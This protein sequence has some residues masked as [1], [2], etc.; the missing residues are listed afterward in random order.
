MIDVV[1]EKPKVSLCSKPYKCYSRNVFKGKCDF[2]HW[3]AEPAVLARVLQACMYNSLPMDMI[4]GPMAKVEKIEDKLELFI[5]YA[6][7]FGVPEVRLTEKE[8]LIS[9]F[10]QEFLF[11]PV[12]DLLQLRDIPKVTRCLAIMAKMVSMEMFNMLLT[13]SIFFLGKC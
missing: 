4:E 8:L 6:R 11:S 13:L 7:R 12:T 3:L 9:S 1:R 2:D 5:K 10:M